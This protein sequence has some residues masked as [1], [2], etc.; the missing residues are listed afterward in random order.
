MFHSP[1]SI[2]KYLRF[3]SK[4]NDFY[5]KSGKQKEHRRQ[6]D[7]YIFLPSSALHGYVNLFLVQNQIYQSRCISQKLFIQHDN[8]EL[9]ALLISDHSGWLRGQLG[10]VQNIF[11]FL[12]PHKA[13]F[14]DS[15]QPGFYFESV[16]FDTYNRFAEG[17]S[18]I[19]QVLSLSLISLISTG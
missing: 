7:S 14:C 17:E 5:T 10:H 2:S 16:Y 6:K 12:F 1:F 3:S 18:H 9:I 8:G 4:L 11:D 13:T 15:S 19:W